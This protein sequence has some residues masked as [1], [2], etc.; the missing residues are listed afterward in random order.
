MG[1]A[2]LVFAVLKKIA[3][4]IPVLYVLDKLFPLYGLG[5]AQLVAE[6]ILSII[7][8]V[9]LVRMFQRIQKPSQDTEVLNGA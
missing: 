3:F 2:S 6:F 8:A 7:A 9:V 4:E 1:K 5:Y